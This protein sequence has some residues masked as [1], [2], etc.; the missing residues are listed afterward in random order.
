MSVK[1]IDISTWQTDVD[2]EKVKAAGIRAVI[3]RAGYG[4]EAAQKD[5][6]FEN[7]YRGARAA[8]LYVGAYWYSYAYSMEGTAA[9][10]R[11]CLACIQGKRFDLPVYYD[12]EEE[13]QKSLGRS[14]LT[15]MTEC[16][17]DLIRAGGFRPGVYSNPDWFENYHDYDLLSAKYSIWLAH[18]ASAHQLACDIWQ[19]SDR[20][21]VP[22][23]SG[24]VD[25]NLIENT[26]V[27]GSDASAPAAKAAPA[28]KF[29]QSVQLGFYY[30]GTDYAC[31]AAQ[32]K[33]VQ[34]LMNWL[35]YRDPDGRVLKVNGV[36]GKETD[37]A[38]R[39]YQK[40]HRLTADGIVGPVTWRLLTG[41]K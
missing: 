39:V 4:R 28:D 41:A 8:G 6:Q 1:C 12:M 23:I 16:F 38:V 32:V 20:G 15:Q 19:Y 13:S 31:P 5:D 2:F 3:I 7:H 21:S 9:E 37:H 26:S 33:T 35:G 10:A 40:K 14:L 24:D 36:F 25:M 30:L 11:A 17:C 29:T 18:W 34:R 27:I 22:G